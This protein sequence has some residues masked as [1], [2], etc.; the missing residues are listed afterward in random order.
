[1]SFFAVGIGLPGVGLIAATLPFL[2]A[3]N[4]TVNQPCRGPEC[5]KYFSVVLLLYDAQ[6]LRL[7]SIR[8]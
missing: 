6:T 4:P 5:C 7:Y 2:V 1:M 3:T 8:E